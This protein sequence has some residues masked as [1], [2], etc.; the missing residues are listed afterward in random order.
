MKHR[1]IAAAAFMLF[2]LGA[3]AQVYG[4]SCVSFRDSRS[5]FEVATAELNGATAVF[6]GK[7]V[8][9][10]WRKG[11]GNESRSDHNRRFGG[12]LEWETKVAIIKVDKWWKSSLPDE[13][14][15]VT[16]EVRTADGTIGNSSCNYDF[17][18]GKSYLVFAYG[19]Q[20][21]LRTNSCAFT[22]QLDLVSKDFLEALGKGNEPIK[23][24]EAEKPK[25]I[26]RF[27]AAGGL[28]TAG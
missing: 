9:F 21:E 6:S 26:S 17:A 10:E 16:D 11:I 14:V 23:K 7:V 25:Q 4:C 24:F 15:L 5:V 20:A 28:L 12:G 19:P 22:R 13:A 3:T 18:E 1:I 27:L 8:R 2:V